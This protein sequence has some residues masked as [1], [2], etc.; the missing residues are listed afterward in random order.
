MGKILGTI[1]LL[2]KEWGELFWQVGI[3]A[4]IW[5]LPLSLII[6]TLFS[7]FSFSI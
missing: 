2:G 4:F 6:S 5:G 1:P 3:M 7:L